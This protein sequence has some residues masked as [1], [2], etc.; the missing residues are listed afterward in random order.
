[1]NTPAA[2]F[3]DG[4]C[5]PCYVVNIRYGVTCTDALIG[6]NPAV[7]GSAWSSA[8]TISTHNSS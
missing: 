3:N 5:V 2:Q 6:R 7:A 8:L 4:A 1:M